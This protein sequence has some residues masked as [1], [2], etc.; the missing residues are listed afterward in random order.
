L[1]SASIDEEH[2]QSATPSPYHTQAL[3][4]AAASASALSFARL[5]EDPIDP[6]KYQCS[7]SPSR[8][9]TSALSA[10]QPDEHQLDPYAASKTSL[11]SVNIANFD[12]ENSEEISRSLDGKGDRSK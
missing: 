9:Q 10:T 5:Q 1:A 2:D 4:F 7:S 6:P 8:P 11:D 3:A 12:L